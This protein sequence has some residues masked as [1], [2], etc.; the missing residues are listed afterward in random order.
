MAN[1][2]PPKLRLIKNGAIPSTYSP[3]TLIQG[4]GFFPAI[5]G[6]CELLP[7]LRFMRIKASLILCIQ[8]PGDRDFKP[9]SF[10]NHPAKVVIAPAPV[11]LPMDADEFNASEIWPHE[12]PFDMQSLDARSLRGIAELAQESS[13]LPALPEKTAEIVEQAI[14]V[15][16]FD[17]R[18][19]KRGVW[20]DVR[21]KCGEAGIKPPSYKTVATQIDRLFSRE[22]LRFHPVTREAFTDKP[23]GYPSE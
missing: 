20:A 2:K 23:A 16:W 8:Y 10:T 7:K 21:T 19:T 3:R 4:N 9:V 12:N 6:S 11:K 14:R 17:G 1:D 18:S 5:P 13:T 15:G 22:V